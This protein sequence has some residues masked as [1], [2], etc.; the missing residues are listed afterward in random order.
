MELISKLN[1]TKMVNQIESL[2]PISFSHISIPKFKM[3]REYKLHTILPGMGMRKLFSDES[4]LSGLGVGKAKVDT[5]IHKA[6]VEVDEEGTV[7]AAATQVAVVPYSSMGFR[8]LRTFIVD[9]PFLFF[10]RDKTNSMTLFAGVVNKLQN[11]KPESS[12]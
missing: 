6:V 5:S 9:H 2:S 4:D 7:A 10:I 3:E 11:A 1:E 8:S 12:T